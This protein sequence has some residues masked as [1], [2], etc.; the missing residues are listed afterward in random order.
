MISGLLFS[1][2]WIFIAFGLIGIYRFKN[3][4]AR[5]LVSSKIDT[6]AFITIIFALIF[7]AGLSPISIRLIIILIFIL[8]TGPVSSHII[9]RSAYLNGIPL[10]DDDEI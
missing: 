4:Y 1:I 9:T 7:E 3:M 2:S 6:V 5:L 10:K 8:L